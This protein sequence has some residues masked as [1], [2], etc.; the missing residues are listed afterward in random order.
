MPYDGWPFFANR[1]GLA[2]Y[3]VDHKTQMTCLPSTYRPNPDT[4]YNLLMWVASR[5]CKPLMGTISAYKVTTPYQQYPLNILQKARTNF[6]LRSS[7]VRGGQLM[8]GLLTAVPNPLHTS[9]QYLF[10]AILVRIR[11]IT[12]NP[13]YYHEQD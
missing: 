8:A 1:M 3:V 12:S 11:S 10:I 6:T 9:D 4:T 13:A 7:R 5:C 2:K